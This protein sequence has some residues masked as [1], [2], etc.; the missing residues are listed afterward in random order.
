MKHTAGIILKAFL[1]FILVIL[2][3]MFIVP[4]IFKDKI[5]VKVE[6]VI[7]E[8]VNAKISFDDYKLGFFRNFPNLSFSLY[9][10][11]VAGADKFVNDTLTS[12][13]SM[14]LVFNLSSLFKKT[15]YEVKSVI[16]KNAS[17]NAVVLEDGSANWDIMKET[18]D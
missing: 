1:G 3:L 7:N 4:V 5:K 17:V 6:Q 18:P 13:E 12:F 14:N 10:V 8:S 11:S 15:G 16:I 9:D 2:V